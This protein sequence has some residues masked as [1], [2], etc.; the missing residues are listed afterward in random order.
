MSLVHLQ[1][2]LDVY[3]RI[4]R[5]G[6]GSITKRLHLGRRDR[7]AAAWENSETA[8]KLWA[9]IP[10]VRGTL[11]A[12]VSG[13]PAVPPLSWFVEKYLRPRPRLRALSLGSG[14]GQVEI[15]LSRMAD[16]ASFEG[17]EISKKLVREANALAEREGRKEVRFIRG[18]L[19]EMDLAEGAYD[20]VFAH[21]SLH[22]FANVDRILA[23]AKSALKPGG[24][25]AFEEYVGPRRFQWRRAQLAAINEL[26]GR[27]PARYRKRYALDVEK[28]RVVAPG[29][30][31]MLISDP[32]EAVDS[33]RI[34]PAVREN[35][36]ILELK[37]I[38][39][40]IAH[41]L[42]HDIAHNFGDGDAEAMALVKMVLDE[43][44]RLIEDGTLQSDFVFVVA[45]R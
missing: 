45:Q 18:D 5:A 6:L 16:F 25:L 37:N 22:H 34:L 20:L 14:P 41:T 21:H 27:I 10:F 31:R 4:R 23:R 42:F 19:L 2:V 9:G 30:L 36:E 13:D 7:V 8:P 11:N 12:R 15:Q 32:S 26:L 28:V 43:E 29:V 35:F 39:G 38:G 17:I 24:L 3:Y 40:T 33:E 44:S 1:D